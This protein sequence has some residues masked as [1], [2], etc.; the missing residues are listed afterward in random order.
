[1][2]HSKK[3]ILSD[4]DETLDQL[5]VNAEILTEIAS[6]AQLEEERLALESLQESLL[7]HLVN[8]DALLKEGKNKLKPAVIAAKL[9]KLDAIRSKKRRT[10]LI[11]R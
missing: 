3:D 9:E 2:L 1:M 10:S 7:S 6:E 4:I 11:P 5:L 8:M